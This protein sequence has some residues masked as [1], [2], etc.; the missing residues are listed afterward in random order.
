MRRRQRD[1]EPDAGCFELY[2]ALFLRHH[3]SV[4]VAHVSSAGFPTPTSLASSPGWIFLAI[5]HRRCNGSLR[6]ASV[7]QWASAEV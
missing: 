3:Y 7:M 5:Q 2:P 1:I 4:R 6:V